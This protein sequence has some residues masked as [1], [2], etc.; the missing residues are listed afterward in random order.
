VKIWIDC[1]NSP[2]PLLFAPVARRLEEQGHEVMVTA[3]NNAQTV[4]LTLEQW[5]EAEVIGAASPRQKGA[6]VAT[7]CQRVADL[8]RWAAGSGPDVALSHN[9]YAQIAAARS[10]G[11]PAVTAMDFEHQPA[12]HLAFRLATTVL[13]PEVLP[14]PVIERQGAVGAKVVTYPGLKEALY[15]GDFEPDGAIVRKLGLDPRPRILAVARTAPTRAVYHSSANPLFEGALQTVC[16]QEGVVCVVLTRH[17]EQR[18]AI[19]RLRLANCVAPGVAIDSRSL[20]YAADVMIGAGGT[21]TREAALMGIPTWTL[22]AG[23]TPAVDLWL[24]RRSMIRRLIR[25]DQLVGLAPRRTEPHTPQELRDRSGRLEEVM[26]R[27]T[28]AAGGGSTARPDRRVLV[29]S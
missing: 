26:V 3:R 28:L 17:E 23:K 29:P 5:P 16:A 18:A 9:S 6:K 4:E 2:H 24:E 13:V 10:L 1:S 8:R 12:N 27:E 25:A 21:M 11:V 19:E 22:F 20:V 15:I 7:L 14:R